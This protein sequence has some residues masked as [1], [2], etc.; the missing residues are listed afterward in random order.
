VPDLEAAQTRLQEPIINEPIASPTLS[1]TFVQLLIGL[2]LVLCVGIAVLAGVVNVLTD[3]VEDLGDQVETLEANQAAGRE[4]TWR[5]QA[6]SC[7][8]KLAIGG[9]VT[10]DAACQDK[11]VLPLYDEHAKPVVVGFTEVVEGG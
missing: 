3:D 7:S 1:N 4:R 9:D 6:L 5:S 11:N 8:I 10:G 2:V